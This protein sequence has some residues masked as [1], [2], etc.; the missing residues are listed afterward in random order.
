M[1]YLSPS[2]IG[3]LDFSWVSVSVSQASKSCC[4]GIH[5]NDPSS[6]K[7]LGVPSHPVTRKINPNQSSRLGPKSVHV[8]TPRS[9][10]SVIVIPASS[11]ISLSIPHTIFSSF[12]TL[13][14]KPFTLPN[15]HHLV[16]SSTDKKNSVAFLIKNVSQGSN[17]R[18]NCHGHGLAG[19]GGNK[20]ILLNDS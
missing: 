8:I 7:D 20:C 6:L 11:S 2:Q 9:S 1:K 17:Y 15:D 3:S 10:Y 19:A 18:S 5:S 13:P 14:P 4:L 12:S 16:L